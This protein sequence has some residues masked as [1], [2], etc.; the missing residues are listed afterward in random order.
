M[1]IANNRNELAKMLKQQRQMAELTLSHS[2]SH[3]VWC[4]DCNRGQHPASREVS[5]DSA[6]QD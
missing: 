6:R 5:D 3:P 1:P 4:H 2:S